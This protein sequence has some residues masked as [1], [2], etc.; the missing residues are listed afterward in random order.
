MRAELRGDGEA[1]SRVAGREGRRKGRRKP[2]GESG[3]KG[4]REKYRHGQVTL[5]FKVGT[6]VLTTMFDVV[7]RVQVIACSTNT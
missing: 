3:A 7:V 4:R 2:Q 5:R 6:T 1:A